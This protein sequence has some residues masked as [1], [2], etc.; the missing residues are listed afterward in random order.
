M[1]Q[2]AA[3]TQ[4][5]QT[6]EAVFVPAL[7]LGLLLGFLIPLPLSNILPRV[8]S[9]SLGVIFFI[10]GLYVVVITRRE[11]IQASQ[12]TDPGRPTTRLITTGIFAWSRNPLYLGGVVTYI[13]LGMLL[14]S[15][16]SLI[17]LIPAVIAAHFI[18]II[19]EERYL[20][21][22]FGEEYQRY[23]RAVRRWFGRRV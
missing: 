3:H 21:I 10:A 4:S 13:S 11:F 19:P 12:P 8:A 6:F 9:I 15:L 20:Q 16:W 7:V 18:L 23:A 2:P 22:Q 5:W 1:N 14:N 17:L